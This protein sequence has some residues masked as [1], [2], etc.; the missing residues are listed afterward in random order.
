VSETSKTCATGATR[1]DES[2]NPSRLSRKSRVNNE[3]RFTDVE[4]AAGGQVDLVYLVCL[5]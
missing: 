5:V 1:E 4:N 2:S 3:I